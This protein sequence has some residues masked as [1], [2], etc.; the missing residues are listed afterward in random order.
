MATVELHAGP[1]IQVELEGELHISSAAELKEKLAQAIGSGRGISVSL[2]RV[3]ALDITAVQLLWAAARKARMA[4]IP[5]T[6]APPV[7]DQVVAG[8]RDAGIPPASLLEGE[9]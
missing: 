7:P 3:S 5:F 8:L 4:G 1:I 9:S 6:F 2:A